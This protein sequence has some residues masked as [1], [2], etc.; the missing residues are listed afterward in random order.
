M[1]VLCAWHDCTAVL[2]AARPFTPPLR[3]PWSR[4]PCPFTPSIPLCLAIA[5]AVSPYRIRNKGTGN[6]LWAPPS[7]Q[8]RSAISFTNCSA[9]GT[10]WL[11]DSSQHLT[12]V[13]TALCITI[14][15]YGLDADGNLLLILA[16]DCSP[17]SASAIPFRYTQGCQV[18]DALVPTLCLQPAGGVAGSGAEAVLFPCQPSVSLQFVLEPSAL[19]GEGEGATCC[20]A[21]LPRTGQGQGLGDRM[22]QPSVSLQIVLEASAL[23]WGGGGCHVFQGEVATIGQGLWDG[24]G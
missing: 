1:C 3:H 15:P 17:S 6:C 24:M 10:T 16:R 8:S 11:F 5:H 19:H 2:A 21:T 4:R 9:E 22:R 7:A 14:S 13:A 20:R 23:H 12:H 18:Q